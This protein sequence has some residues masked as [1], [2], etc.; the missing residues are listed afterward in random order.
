MTEGE[1]LACD[2][3][4]ALPEFVWQSAT[5]R[6]VQLVAVACCRRIWHLLDDERSRVAVEVAERFADGKATDEELFDACDAAREALDLG[7][8]NLAPGIRKHVHT[9]HL[10]AAWDTAALCVTAVSR[11]AEWRAEVNRRDLMLIAHWAG[12]AVAHAAFLA[13]RKQVRDGRW[14]EIV[15][16]E[17]VAQTSLLRDVFGNPFRSAAVDPVW[18]AWNDGTVVK[19]ARVIYDEKQFEDVTLLGDAVEEAGCT[20]DEILLHCQGP[21][22]DVR[23]L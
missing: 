14:D 10:R 9:A 13:R 11:E 8:R 20:D 16:E 6:Q 12:T 4:R 7:Y 5:D 2:D 23:G 15:R 1:W 18:L 17:T 3:L 19:M 22:R 21:G